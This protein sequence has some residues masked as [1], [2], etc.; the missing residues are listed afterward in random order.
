[1]TSVCLLFTIIIAN[2]VQGLSAKAHRHYYSLTTMSL[3][4]FS[5]K[6]KKFYHVKKTKQFHRNGHENVWVGFFSS[7]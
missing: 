7:G 5:L 2:F 3:C 4:L 6:V 1:M